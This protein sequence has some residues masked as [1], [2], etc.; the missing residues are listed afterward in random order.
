[1]KLKEP[2]Y[3]LFEV[4]INQLADSVLQLTEQQWID[5]DL[6]Q[7]KYKVHNLTQ[8]Y[9]F[10]FSEY[11]EPAKTY[12]LNTNVWRATKPI[13][14]KLENFYN[15]KAD[16]IFL[17]KLLPY[18]NIIPHKDGGWFVDTHRVHVPIITDPRIMFSLEGK[19]FHMQRGYAYELNNIIEHGV[20][21][22]TEL[23]RVHLMVDL[24]P[25]K[26]LDCSVPI[27]PLEKIGYDSLKIDIT[28]QDAVNHGH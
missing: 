15:R 18:K 19:E 17:V 21:N 7:N 26:I 14:D 23:G 20:T 28:H 6:R 10:Y 25:N 1:M 22:P 13:I 27:S 5:W 3:K 16:V 9:P 8:S 4:D 2:I 24:H 12:N 11:G